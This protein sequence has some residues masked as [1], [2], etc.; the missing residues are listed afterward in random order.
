MIEKW[1]KNCITSGNRKKDIQSTFWSELDARVVTETRWRNFD[2][3]LLGTDPSVDLTKNASKIVDIKLRRLIVGEFAWAWDDW[4]FHF[5]SSKVR[6]RKV[7]SLDY[8]HHFKR[9]WVIV[10]S[11]SLSFWWVIVNRIVIFW[12]CFFSF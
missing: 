8:F 12:P 1:W 3:Y 4:W 5:K 11:F 9:W 7:Y 2:P 10:T 6:L